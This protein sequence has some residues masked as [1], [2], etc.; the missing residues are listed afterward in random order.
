METKVCKVCGIEKSVSEYY[1][2]KDNQKYRNDC[3]EC[4]LKNKKIYNQE[5]SEH[6]KE[7]M[8]E[9]R[10][11]NPTKHSEWRS[12]NI[13]RVLD[14]IRRWKKENPEKNRE[15]K[16]N[17]EK[18]RLDTDPKYKLKSNIRKLVRLTFIKKEYKKHKHTFEILGISHLGFISH[19]ESQFLDG[20]NWENKN[21]WEIDH[22]IPISITR[23]EEEIIK[24]NHYSNLRPLWRKDNRDKSNK[25][26]EEHKGLMYKLLGEDFVIE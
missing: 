14:G 16:N 9:Y 22:I 21:K 5:N 23:N 13:E 18:K 20:M 6:R 3:K 19:I 17:T 7:Y 10:I 24:L 26:L 8:N 25:I 12:E 4:H 2:R 11:N 1:F 15:H